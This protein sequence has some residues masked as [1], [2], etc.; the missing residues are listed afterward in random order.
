[1]KRHLIVFGG[2]HD[3]PLRGG[4][5]KYFNDV[6]AFDTQEMRWKKLEITG[7]KAPSTR[8]GCNMFA[9]SDGRII[10]YGG[11][12]KENIKNKA[13]S[14]KKGGERCVRVTICRLIST[15]LG[16]SRRTGSGSSHQHQQIGR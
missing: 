1:M 2:F 6:H 14:G 4:C 7:V 10:V 11:Y 15:G 8:S 3:N 16:S 12:C 13:G 9:L 5:A